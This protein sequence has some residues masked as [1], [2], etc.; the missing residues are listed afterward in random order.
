MT[1]QLFI[2]I[3]SNNFHSVQKGY[4][5]AAPFGYPVVALCHGDPAALDLQDMTL[6][7]HVPQQIIHGVD[8][9]VGQ[10]ITL[11]YGLV[12]GLVL[13]RLGWSPCPCPA[14]TTRGSALALP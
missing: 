7:F 13:P 2:N 8:V 10:L 12:M 5:T 1:N 3:E 4:S 6:H 11:G 9:E 14:I